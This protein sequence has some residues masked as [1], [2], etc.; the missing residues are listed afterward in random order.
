MQRLESS[1]S[2]TFS[3]YRKGL[4]L[5]YSALPLLLPI[6]HLDDI[7]HSLITESWEKC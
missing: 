3:L 1:D 2:T 7:V 5:S 4:Y 6:K